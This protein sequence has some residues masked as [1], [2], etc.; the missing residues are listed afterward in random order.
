MGAPI[1]NQFWKLRSKHGI[2]KLFTDP[3]V[4]EEELDKYLD[5]TSQRYKETTQASAG[6]LVTIKH[7]VPPTLKGFCLF[8]GV[9]SQYVKDFERKMESITDPQTRKDFGVVLSRIREAI[10]VDQVEGGLAG[11]YNPGLTARLNGIKDQ[12]DITSNNKEIKGISAI[13]YETPPDE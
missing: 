1:G 7:P 11:V 5:L 13:I 8:L 3:K 12:T 9:H 10:E 2:T 4:L 6:K